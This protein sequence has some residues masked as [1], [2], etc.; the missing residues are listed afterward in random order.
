MDYTFT[1]RMQNHYYNKFVNWGVKGI[2]TELVVG[3]MK[4]GELMTGLRR[5]LWV[6]V[7][8]L[9]AEYLP[10]QQPATHG[11]LWKVSGN[12]LSQPSYLFA[13]AS[14]I[15]PEQL[16]LPYA[17]LRTLEQT[18]QLVLTLDITNPLLSQQVLEEMK[19]PEGQNI[20]QWFTRT[21][22][23]QVALFYKDSLGIN[24][25]ELGRFQPLYVSSY[26]YGWVLQCQ[27]VSVEQELARQ[28]FMQEKR[29][30]GLETVAQQGAMFRAIPYRQQA[31]LLIK[32]L[33]DPYELKHYYADM[34]VSYKNED[35]PS[36]YTIGKELSLGMSQY[37]EVLLSQ[38]NQR[39]LPKLVDY[40]GK[41]PTFVAI[42]AT[43]LSGE[44]GLISLLKQQGYQ[45]EA[46]QF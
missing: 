26:M 12:G 36:L 2:I 38:R 44:N 35:L 23:E 25:Q 37:E 33:E 6:V 21:E 8:C 7:L 30:Y 19:L 4:K 40:F 45:L 1:C 29:I 34:V 18:D 5:C 10:A 42:N 24:L 39:W 9:S 27:A 46:V 20:S 15:C 43:H 11:L 13:T 17:A 16:N 41:S 28:A 22:Y 14:A 32:A 3:R 31:K